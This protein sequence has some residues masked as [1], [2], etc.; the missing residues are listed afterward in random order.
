MIGSATLILLA[1]A[2]MVWSWKETNPTKDYK[3]FIGCVLV[4]LFGITGW[5]LPKIMEVSLARLVI[6]LAG[7]IFPDQ[8]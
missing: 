2:L 6:D 7:K 3:A 5:F 4:I 1:I 8:R